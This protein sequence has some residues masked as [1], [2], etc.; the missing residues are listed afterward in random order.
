[1]TPH[2]RSNTDCMA[3][4]TRGIERRIEARVRDL[5]TSQTESM[6]VRRTLPTVGQRSVGP[7]VFFDHFGPTSQAMDVPPHPHIGLATVTTLFEGRTVHRD[8]TGVVQ[9]IE[10]GAV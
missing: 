10:P 2:S 5:G 1:M 9:A 3:G 7:F 8:S 6:T 4:K